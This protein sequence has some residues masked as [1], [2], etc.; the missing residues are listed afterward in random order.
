ME[1]KDKIGFIGLGNMGKPMAKNLEQAGVPLYVYNRTPEKMNDFSEKSIP[2]NDI[3]SLVKECD[4]IFTMLTNDDAVHAVYE[5]ILSM[6]IAGKLFVDMSTISQE[7]SKAISET[8]KLKG[9]SFI[10]A[11]VAGSTQPAKDGTLIFMVGGDEADEKKVLPYLEIMGKEVKYMGANGQ[12]VNAKLCINYYLS[13]LYQGMAE[14][15]LF[16]EKMGISRENMMSIINESASGSGASK[17]KTSMI[18]KDEYPAAFSIDLML[19]DVKLAV[20]AGAK[21]PLTDS[22]LKTYQGAKDAGFATYDVM[23]VIPFMEDKKPN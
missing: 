21:Y 19:K 8:T 11:P 12:G 3:Y 7:A 18:I 20:E 16:A 4:I 14:T 15:V 5:T 9:A 10:D 23:S 2:C 13:I 17:V 6:D 22:V 1:Y